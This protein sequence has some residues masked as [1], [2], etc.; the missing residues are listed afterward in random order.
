M[1]DPQ[2]VIIT[3]YLGSPCYMQ[4]Q[5]LVTV[6]RVSRPSACQYMVLFSLACIELVSLAHVVP[7]YVPVCPV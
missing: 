4:Q 6:I 2:Q 1:Q 7:V 5:K 3:L